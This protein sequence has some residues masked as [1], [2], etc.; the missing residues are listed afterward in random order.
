MGPVLDVSI[1]E[2]QSAFATNF[3]SVLRLTQVVVP[4]MASRSIQGT[5]GLV[6][7]IGSVTAAVPAPW[8]G[9]YASTKAALRSVSETMYMEFQ[10]IGVG[11]LLVEPG[12][13]RS[14]VC[15]LHSISSGGAASSRRTPT[16]FSFSLNPFF[17][18][19]SSARLCWRYFTVY[20]RSDFDSHPTAV[21]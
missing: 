13:I 9:I 1:N 21:N 10:P 2:V 14:N 17:L 3:F 7:N 12:G 15:T 8:G 16:L 5:K 20:A 4:H 6:I 18:S 19:A 11:V